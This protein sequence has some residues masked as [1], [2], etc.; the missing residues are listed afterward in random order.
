M[1]GRSA[2]HDDV[3]N[4]QVRLPKR[5]RSSRR[6]SQVC[7]WS[8]HIAAW[9]WVKGKEALSYPRPH[10]PIWFCA[11][12]ALRSLSVRIGLPFVVLAGDLIPGTHAARAVL[13]SLKYAHH[14]KFYLSCPCQPPDSAA[15]SRLETQRARELQGEPLEGRSVCEF[16]EIFHAETQFSSRKRQV[17]RKSE[18]VDRVARQ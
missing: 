10:Y 2:P 9:A 3:Q 13:A 1:R 11:I 16:V 8:W 17:R 14:R 12:L 7:G 6:A 5:A 18:C 15:V 4:P